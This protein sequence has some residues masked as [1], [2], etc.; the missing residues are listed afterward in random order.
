V[1]VSR[2][3]TRLRA[4]ANGRHWR[5]ESVD[6]EFDARSIVVYP[7]TPFE[8]GRDFSYVL[9]GPGF[10]N[11][12]G[13]A[14]LWHDHYAEEY[15]IRSNV[16]RYLLN[17]T[18][19]LRLGVEMKFMEYQWIDITRP[20]VGAPIQIDEDTFSETNRLGASSDIWNVSPARGA[21]YISDQIRYQGL[22]ANI[23]MRLEYW[24]PGSYV[25]NF[26][27]DPLS[28]IPNSIREDYKSDTFNFFGR[29][30]KMRMLPRINVSFPVRENM[31][32]YFNYSH[33]SKLPHPSYV[34]A[35][36]DPFFQDRSFLSDLGNPNLDPEVDISYE[37]GFRYQLTSND[38][39]NI[40]AFW[41]D[42]YDFITA[43]RII[44]TDATGRDTERS[45]RVN[46]DFA[47]V[48]GLEVSY[49]KRYSHF[50]Q[51]S[52]NAT[53]SRAEG[54]S[55]TS[56]DALTDLIAGGQDIGNNIETPLAWDRPIDI[57]SSMIFTW[58]RPNNPLFGLGPLNQFRFYL[59][60]S[61][62]SGIRYTPME[63][64]GNQR[65]P[66]TGEEDWRPVYERSNDPSDRFSA[67][68]EPWIMFDF[69]FQKW[70]ELG[71][72]RLTAKLEITNLLNTRNPAI[73]NP[74]TGKAY[75][76]DYP[77]SQDALVA[78]RN[79]R[80]YDVPANVRDPRYVDP[81][82]NNSPAYLNPANFLEQRHIMFGLEIN[83]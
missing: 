4:D 78:L 5:P 12:G 6:G 79:D 66:V 56:N 7:V 15:T 82:D 44:V 37:I 46:G 10:A 80:S 57:K 75:R 8:A 9:P 70:F 76:T 50:L 83:F 33:K 61:Y 2:L 64:R 47:R 18:H 27:D 43:E 59:S 14:T 40:T 65:N 3:F 55:S 20:W 77:A 35:G 45:F 31:V 28:P 81:R 26:V 63:F 1:Q 42:K 19:R 62:R 34:Y 21:F 68:G 53:Y 58:D 52:I 48:R 71:G 54:L 23:G 41:S 17:E 32:M 74:V 22:I 36:L 38:A 69:N 49:L 11:N 30:F 67:V 29:R 13:I 72:T 60:G 39:L 51:G 16:T 73:I 24:F 25:D